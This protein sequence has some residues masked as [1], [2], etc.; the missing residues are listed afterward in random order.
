YRRFGDAS[1]SLE[2]VQRNRL[3]HPGFVPPGT[4]KIAQE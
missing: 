3:A 2:I 4:L 1:R